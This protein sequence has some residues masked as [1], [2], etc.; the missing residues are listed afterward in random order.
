MTVVTES[1]E[2]VDQPLEGTPRLIAKVAADPTCWIVSAFQ[3]ADG[4]RWCIQPMDV[5]EAADQFV[6]GP[7]WAEDAETARRTLHLIARLYMAARER[8]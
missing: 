1:Y 8:I 7:L 4:K 5:Q 6:P 3:G 2:I